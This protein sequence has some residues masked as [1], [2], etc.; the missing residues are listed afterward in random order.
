MAV[1]FAD[2]LA[3]EKAKGS[4][5]N[6][7]VIP[8]WA[9]EGQREVW[10]D[11][12]QDIIACAGTQGGKTAL[13][14]YWLLREIYR[15]R[16][17]AKQLGVGNHI[18]AGPT[19]TLLEAQ[20]IPAFEALFVDE[21]KLGR[22]V[23]GGKTKFYFSEEGAKRLCGF[24][25][26]IVVHF[27]YAN[28]SQNLESMTALSA[29]WDEVGQPDNKEASFEAMNRRLKIARAAGFGRRLFTTTPYEWDWFK[30]RLVDYVGRVDSYGY[31]SWPSWLNPLMS[32]E[33]CRDELARGMEKWRWE[34]MYEGKWTRPAGAVY[35]CFDSRVETKAT[36]ET[37]VVEPFEIPQDWHI[38]L[39]WDFGPANTACSAYAEDPKTG[40]FYGFMS[41]HGAS[42]SAEKHVQRVREKTKRKEQ[43]AWGGS[44]G[45]DE[46]RRKY[47]QAG[48]FIRLSPISGPGS[49]GAGISAG[50]QMISTRKVK[51]FS[52]LTSMISELQ[53]MSYIVDGDGRVTDEVRDKRVWHRADTFRAFA[54]ATA[55]KITPKRHGSRFDKPTVSE[56]D[57]LPL[58]SG[59]TTN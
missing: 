54:S 37:N 22:L 59:A 28:D 5:L 50:Y 49:V 27:A 43:I 11:D 55:R 39:G 10:E 18:Y 31:H 24:A 36:G 12:R 51:W 13:N 8:E 17:L 30:R 33:G 9:H 26:K 34:M 45:E 44:N 16:F 42:E 20:A 19:L 2:F 35:D 4:P 46:W 48:M 21:L 29:V 38:H 23:K 41:Y 3:S 53:S 58:R 1:A 7:E 6:P 32:E 57:L 52:T 56:R 40:I 14:P 15:T 25:V 47:K